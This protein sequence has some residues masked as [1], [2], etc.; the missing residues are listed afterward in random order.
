[1]GQLEATSVAFRDLREFISFVEQRGQ[2]NRVRTGVS[3]ELEITEITDRVVKSGGPALFFEKVTGYSMPVV[4]N[5]LGTEQRMAWALGVDTLDGLGDKVRGLL[6]FVQE[7]LPSSMM[8]KLKVLGALA[9][10]SSYAPKAVSKGVSQEV[11]LTDDASLKRLPVLKCWPLDGGPFITLPLVITKDPQTG[12]RNV[13]MYRMQVYDA[14]TAGLHWHAHKDAAVH[15]RHTE[16]KKQPMPVAVALGT[17]P[18]TI[19]A[20]TAPLPLGMDELFFSGFLRGSGVEMVKAKT[21]D[22]EVPANA[23]IILEGY[24]D[25]DERRL[26][27]PFGDHT[28]YYSLADEYPV[29][30]LTA[31]THRTNPIYPATIVGRPPMEDAYI[32]KATERLALPILQLALPEVVDMNLP[33]EGAFHNLAI[34]S[35]KKRYPGQP[36]KVMCSIWGMMPLALTKTIIIVDEHVD[37]HNTSEV[38]WRVTTSIDPR[39]DMMFVDGPL[40]A[41]DHAS[42]RPLFGSK[43]GI[44]ATTKGPMD[45]YPR[46]WPPDIVMSD[47]IK[48]MVSHK[49]GQYGL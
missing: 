49:W 43:V 15:Y 46:E 45:G 23:E 13:G 36:Q 3:P 38:V 11:V 47:E 42:P 32:G 28:G 44:D 22:L 31:I 39:R 7:P 33:V 5:L 14:R 40:D 8:D 18:A 2:L 4:T 25:P 30:H 9:E 48:E 20:A 35:I 26:E 41:L 1:M 37:V 19:Y 10:I 24:V 16:E 34:V 12:K 6:K 17:D 21:V 29:F 27:G